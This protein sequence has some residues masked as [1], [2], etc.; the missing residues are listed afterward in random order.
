MKQL[1]LAA[2]LVLAGGVIASASGIRGDYV[3]SRTADV[4]T[5]PCF[6]NARPIRWA[7]CGVRVEH[8]AGLLQGVKLDGCRWPAV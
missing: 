7:T 3:E 2:L 4:Y 1:L 6:A 8:P 5:G